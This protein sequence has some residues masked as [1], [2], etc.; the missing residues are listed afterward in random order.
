MNKIRVLKHLD[1]SERFFYHRGPTQQKQVKNIKNVTPSQS[2]EGQ[3]SHEAGS[4]KPSGLKDGLIIKK[5]RGG[6]K[7]IYKRKNKRKE[8]IICDFHFK[9][10]Y[11]IT[12]R[13][14]KLRIPLQKRKRIG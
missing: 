11:W 6:D 5:L 14:L 7:L 10:R 13:K 3:E 2:K 8:K 1:N 4:K 9:F 12:T